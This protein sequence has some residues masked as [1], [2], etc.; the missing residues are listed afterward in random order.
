MTVVPPYRLYFRDQY[1]RIVCRLD[2]AARGDE[3]AAMQAEILATICSDQ[4]DTFE[5]WHGARCI[6]PVR[7]MG[8]NDDAAVAAALAHPSAETF[9][10]IDKVLLSDWPLAQSKQLQARRDVL[11]RAATATTQALERIR[12]NAV[13][14]TGADF[15]NIQA[16]EGDALRIAAHHGFDRAFLD[17][18]ALVRNDST[19]C[20]A[21]IKGG[22]RIVVDDVGASP[23]YDAASR[24]AMLAAACRSCQ[25]TP[26]VANGVLVG[27]LSTHRRIV[28]H[29]GPDEL[30]LIDGFAA[31]AS[32]ALRAI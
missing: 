27:M 26:L 2:L 17:F 4:C 18:F 3:H 31:E 30:H 13:T 21:A 32:A 23:I 25:S 8:Q 29:P 28:W 1:R 12:T 6:V 20:G 22:E 11:C 9:D 5:V 15:G 16:V 10:L 14:A 19:A 7:R 24:H